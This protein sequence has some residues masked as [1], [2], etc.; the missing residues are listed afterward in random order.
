[1]GVD[2]VLG[3]LGKIYYR[4]DKDTLK[5]Y[6]LTQKEKEAVLQ[7]AKETKEGKNGNG[8]QQAA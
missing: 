4:F 5:Y 6:E 2:F 3:D 8:Q 7:S 1:M